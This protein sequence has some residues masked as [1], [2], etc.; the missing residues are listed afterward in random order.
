MSDWQVGDLAVCVSLHRD[1]PPIIRVGNVYRVEWVT[2]ELLN[3]ETG[4]IG[5]G[6]DF[7]GV[8]RMDDGTCSYD[9]CR[10]RKV[11]PDKHESCE[12]EFV[13]LL[14]HIRENA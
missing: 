8:P 4:T 9:P 10:F 1:F 2:P 6:L 14:K 5:V 13:T 7:E 3:M 11:T 12:D